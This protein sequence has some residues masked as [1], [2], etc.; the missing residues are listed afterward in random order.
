MQKDEYRNDDFIFTDSIEECRRY[1]DADYCWHLLCLEGSAHFAVGDVQ[2]N[3]IAGGAVIKSSSLPLTDLVCSDDFRCEALLISWRFLSANL[4]ETD[5]NVIGTLA[6]LDNPVM[7]MHREDLERCRLN[8]EEIR[9]RTQEPYH[10]FYSLVMRR[11]VE[12]MI[13]DFYDIHART[14]GLNIEGVSQPCRILQRFINLL[15]EGLYRRERSVEYYAGRLF[16][17]PKYLSECCI[18]VSG[19][20]ASGW[21]EHYTTQ[22]IAR[23]L[24]DK[25][26]SLADIADQ[27]NFSSVSY[28]SRYVSRTFG[29]S[30]R[31][32]R[33]G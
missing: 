12:T 9:R 8:F 10:N 20:N 21:I 24:S 18:A 33:K 25:H 5:Y 17:S 29:C 22:E 15:Q 1:P 4:P 11:A 26:N 16:I 13:L 23:L 3:V 7:P 14:T 27:L 2:C 6:M 28:L 19:R 32:F 31:E 30:P